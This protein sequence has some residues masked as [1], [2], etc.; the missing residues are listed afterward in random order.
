MLLVTEVD[1]LNGSATTNI[2]AEDVQ[3]PLELYLKSVDLNFTSVI[4]FGNR[5]AL[6]K[7]KINFR[8]SVNKLI[9]SNAVN[10]A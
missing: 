1:K 10:L 4:V 2:S 6:S 3:T 8:E 7:T 9:T 5:L